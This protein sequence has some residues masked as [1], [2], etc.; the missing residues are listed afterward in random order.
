MPGG[1]MARSV[2]VS[3][4]S[5][6]VDDDGLE[7]VEDLDV[8]ADGLKVPQYGGMG[9]S[10]SSLGV[11]VSAVPSEFPSSALPSDLAMTVGDQDPLAGEA[12]DEGSDVDEDEV[13]DEDEPR[14][15]PPVAPPPL[16]RRPTLSHRVSQVGQM[17]QNR[18]SVIHEEERRSS[19]DTDSEEKLEFTKVTVPRVTAPPPQNGSALTAA[20][21]AHVPH[22]VSTA[23]GVMP[24]DGGVTPVTS[25]PFASLYASVAAPPTVPSLNLELF[26]P[27]N[28]PLLVT[29][30]KDATVEEVTGHGLWK[31]VEEG[32]EPKLPEENNTTI[33]WGLRIVEDDG[34]IDED[35]PRRSKSFCSPA[36][37]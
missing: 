2:S 9:Y 1:I 28:P 21:N 25:N 24:S 31:Y 3:E 22:L 11:A 27:D 19:T 37:F 13:V 33:D 35:F 16:A 6:D 4:T 18:V 36:T 32:R 8:D 14:A 34:E 17:P 20:L 7:R 10:G 5:G 15:A 23:V 29:V 30:R 12:V 26:F